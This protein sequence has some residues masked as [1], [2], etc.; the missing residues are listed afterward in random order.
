MS[1]EPS[2]LIGPPWHRSLYARIA[3]GFVLLIAFVLA[4][5]GGVVLWLVGRQVSPNLSEV[6][7]A[8]GTELSRELEANPAL[9]LD[10]RVRGWPRDQHVFVIMQD[11]RVVGSRTPPESTV[12]SVIEYLGRG[13]D[14]IPESY[15]QSIYLAVP[16]KANRRLVGTLGIVP[17]TILE[18]YGV[19]IAAIGISLL[20]IGT[21]VASLT[22]FGPVRSRIL[23]LGSAA[24]RLR[25]GDLTA[26]ARED[27]S[28]EVA[29]LA[30]A[31][32]SMADELARRT[33]ALEES[34]RVRR[35]LIADVSHEL[36]TPLTAV[37]GHLETLSMAEVRLDDER[38]L[39]HVAIA[40]REAQ[41]LERL[42]GDLLD[43]ARLEAGG[44]DLE[45]QPVATRDVFDEVIAHHGVD[46]RTRN[47]R[48]VCSVAPDA[49]VVQADLFRLAQ[50]LENV[51]ANAMRHTPDGGLIKLEAERLG[52]NVVLTVADSG[53]GIPE[54]HL[55][56][57]F[58]RFYKTTSAKGIAS[59]GTG[60]GLSIVK[61]IVTRHGGR[62]SA[63]STLGVGTTIQLEFP[64]DR[65]DDETRI[66]FGHDSFKSKSP[67]TV[68]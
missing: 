65:I 29:E 66:L 21:L 55:P 58:D 36:M 54:E 30:R 12:R 7:T 31:F 63:R 33:G 28:D 61:A 1:D 11:G 6:T 49:E 4:V 24:D 57:I 15:R 22:I 32:N 41:R 60:L 53:E 34:D 5:Q 37:L 16:V 20:V 23:G 47:I 59:R 45:I 27:G 42:I 62:V 2:R 46:C 38:R 50:A 13:Y 25:A 48:F 67:R 14:D 17:P 10:E 51:T 39:W 9:N 43:A 3:I 35:Q 8:L 68:I 64:H 40:T 18:R 56:L 19:E 26:R 52:P 44:G